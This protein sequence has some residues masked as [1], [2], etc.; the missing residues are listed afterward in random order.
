MG[1]VFLEGR[2]LALEKRDVLPFPRESIAG[3]VGT[4][5]RFSWVAA[6]WLLSAVSAFAQSR[7]E[8]SAPR[9]GGGP[10]GNA[11][12]YEA[13]RLTKVVRAVRITEKIAVDGSLEDP[14]WKLA[15]PAT[16]FYQYQPDPGELSPERTE[17]RFL[18]DDDNLYVAFHSWDSD[19]AHRTVTELK[20]DFS[21]TS[22]DVATLVIDSL[23]DRQSG[24]Q[25]ATNAAGAK[26]DS[27]ISND[28][29]YNNDWDGVWDV[30]VSVQDDGWIAEFVIPFTTFRFSNAPTQEWGLNLGRKILRRNEDSQ[31]APIP[32]RYRA[33]SKVSLA[34]IL[35][36]LENIRPGRN[37]K[38]KPY[39][40]GGST[41][42]RTDSPGLPSSTMRLT[43]SLARITD[44][45]GGVD[46]K[47]GVGPSLTLDA[48]YHTDFAQVEVDQQQVN[49]TRFSLFFPEKRDFFIENAGNFGFG[50][51]GGGT[52]RNTGGGSSTGASG[53]LSPFY[54]RRIGLSAA[55]T[56]IPIIGGTRLSG[57]VGGAYD[58]GFL[59]MKTDALVARDGSGTVLS[60]TP[61][62]NYVVGRVRRN[63]LRNSF[64]G[65]LFTSRNSTLED[66][67][68]RVYGADAFF[69]LDKWQ[70]NG[71]L[72]R[73]DTPGKEGRNHARKLG[74]AWQ[75]DEL[76]VS[77]EYNSVQFNFNPEV[78]FLRRTNFSQYTGDFAWTPQLRR[79][80]TIR[81]LDFGARV[82]YYEDGNGSIETR[83]EDMNF[84]I[85]FENN[86][87]INY[88]INETFDRL[89][90]PTRIG[91]AIVPAGDYDY[92]AHTASFS[93]NQTRMISGSGNV[94]WGEFWDGDRTS[95]GGSLGFTPNYH[96]SVD[97]TY[98]RN[99]V[100]LP[101]GAF[102]TDLVGMRLVY[103]FTGRASLNAFVQ[104]NTDTHQV[105]L[106]HPV[107]FHPSPAERPLP[108]LQ[109]PSRHE[110]RRA[111]RAI[112]HH[113]SDEPLRFLARGAI[114]T[115]ARLGIGFGLR[116]PASG[117]GFSVDAD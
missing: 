69:E 100:T 108:G 15:L 58:V 8:G 25:F 76:Y 112:V 7:P 86:G 55:G 47:Y 68:N 114:G 103:A 97:T 40:S 75:D 105:Q 32:I 106:E 13:V 115:L 53:N 89:V 44:Y 31:W 116:A 85:V 110:A 66:D 48:T 35:T 11:I 37:L 3:I 62:N 52:G 20:E 12:D 10:G 96:L 79:S 107:Q 63:L 109:R 74:A 111:H 50:G 56:P 61:S 81:N 21:P 98:S 78:G 46:L 104:F 51:G 94:S 9:A 67:Y 102:T 49:L 36:G 4:M 87:S 95:F 92:L 59:A 80:P 73:S 45:D 41:Q 60:T 5:T 28:G 26:R 77:S 29:Q 93:T 22:S 17:V 99:N 65:A 117:L 72:L 71:Y 23:H 113:Q 19:M 82:D 24:Y 33:I 27:Q 84:G 6:L 39:V 34:G 88:G 54:S 30:K 70:F 90:A 91:G 2:N 42:V 43:Q 57:K 16:E 18:Y 83:T 1:R 101:T 38:I 14:A 64:V